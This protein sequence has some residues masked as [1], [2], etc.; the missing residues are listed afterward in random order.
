MDV[1]CMHKYDQD[2]LLPDWIAIVIP[3]HVCYE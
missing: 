2:I 3:G 1:R